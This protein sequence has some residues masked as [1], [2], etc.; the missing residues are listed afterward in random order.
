MYILVARRFQLWHP[1]GALE[2][3]S[4]PHRY[5]SL[6]TRQITLN[7][8]H[9]LSPQMLLNSPSVQCANSTSGVWLPDPIARDNYESFQEKNPGQGALDPSFLLYR[10]AKTD[11]GWE[12][13]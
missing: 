7:E 11:F 13:W 3:V 4:H 2:I 1:S 5:S 9:F 12:G 8:R 6:S 10:D